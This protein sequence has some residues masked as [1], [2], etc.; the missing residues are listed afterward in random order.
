MKKLSILLIALGALFISTTA[1]ASAPTL[2]VSGS[3]DSVQVRVSASPNTDVWLKYGDT[4]GASRSIWIGT[5]DSDGYFSNRVSTSAS[6][7]AS[8]SQVYVVLG[9]ATTGARSSNVSWPTPTSAKISLPFDKLTIGVSQ[10]TTV[11]VFSSDSGSVYVK[12]LS[13][14]AASAGANGGI[15]TVQGQSVGQTVVTVCR[16]G[17]TSNCTDLTVTVQSSGNTTAGQSFQFSPANPVVTVGQN[18]VV[19]I[20]GLVSNSFYVSSN[21]NPSIAQVNIT[22]NAITIY[23]VVIGSASVTVCQNSGACASLPVTV[24]AKNSASDKSPTAS[25][26]SLAVT[27]GRSGTVLVAGTGN[28]TVASNNENIATVELVQGTN[29]VVTGVVPGTATVSACDT[30]TRCAYVSVVVT[31]APAASVSTASVSSVASAPRYVFTTFLGVGSKGTAVTQLQKQLTT[32]GVYQGPIT[33]YY[34][35]LTQAA[36][37]KFQSAHAVASVGYVGPG[38]R[39][40]LN[41]G[42]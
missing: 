19:S 27:V 32:L 18:T 35:P 8:G 41:A 38:T 13:G 22:N 39:A 36:V 37:K 33:G 31:Q 25:Q 16:T 20:G 4:S 17:G 42:S 40:A 14:S 1:Y 3:G 29:L 7:I 23:G 28:Y 15:L 26:S 34:G 2:S 24:I 21:S 5:T 9:N 12:S 30:S 11:P 10:S 6:E